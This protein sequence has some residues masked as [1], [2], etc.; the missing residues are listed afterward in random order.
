MST[1]SN[2]TN[3]ATTYSAPEPAI[4]LWKQDF[5]FSAR[6]DGGT[7]D[8]SSLVESVTWQ[9]Q[10]SDALANINTQCAM[11]GSITMRKP[12]LHQYDKLLPAVF[13]ARV[14][15]LGAL[16]AVIICSIGYGGKYT[17]VWAMRCSPGENATVAETV[18]LSD[19]T[20]TLNL[21]DDLWT[22]GLTKADFKYTKGKVIRKQGWHAH[23]IAADVCHKMKVPVKQLA[24]G[25]SWFDLPTSATTLV[26]PLAVIVAAY[27]EET[28]R[29]GKT[30]IVRWAAPDSKNPTGALE[31]IPMRRN[32]SL[33]KFRD[34]LINAALTRSQAVDFATV[35][36]A[37][38]Y[39]KLASGKHHNITHLEINA[40]GV[41]RFGWVQ[42]AVQF[43]AVES[44]G[45]L[46]TL[47]KRVLA[48]RLTPIRTAELT[49]PGVATIRRGDAIRIDLPEEG[50][51]QTIVKAL[52]TPT[53]GA[54]LLAAEKKDPS[55]FG[56]PD[57]SLTAPVDPNAAAPAEP[58]A[59]ALT[60]ALLPVAD[61]GI[62][63][64]TS[65]VHAAAAGSYTVDMQTGFIDVLDPGQVKTQIDAATR[66]AK[67]PSTV[68]QATSTTRIG[69][70]LMLP[71]EALVLIARHGLPDAQTEL[72][73][74]T[75]KL[76]YFHVG[77][78]GTSV[79]DEVGSFALVD[80]NG[81]LASYVGN[82]LAV[83]L[84]RRTVF[85]YVIGSGMNL[86]APLMLTRRAFLE[87]SLLVYDPIYARVAVKL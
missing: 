57:P 47:A 51:G 73:G 36:E 40:A 74:A 16:G 55:L 38:G 79:S 5:R 54:G 85:V 29:T 4:D 81:P 6:V 17:P 75:N 77:W 13:S 2:H 83:T 63:F 3:F 72:G 15:H 50:Y 44:M 86:G 34:Q 10:S 65:V 64:V 24:T 11:I 52:A 62:A 70:W 45:E 39:L 66:A 31:V 37:R 49:H 14:G 33:L 20:W 42:K 9:D 80:A 21:A 22:I 30:F 32:P 35:I 84:A 7:Y 61:A 48:V 68:P 56:L 53:S 46:V 78:Y 41:K 1:A 8:I 69:R 59:D 26:S 25:T 12:A 18:G 82:I 60:P 28:K 71:P 23:E 87:I 19:G 58:A 76:G 27:Q 67:A 43:N